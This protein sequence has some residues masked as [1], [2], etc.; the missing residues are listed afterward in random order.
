MTDQKVEIKKGQQGC[1]WSIFLWHKGMLWRMNSYGPL[2]TLA[3]PTLAKRTVRTYTQRPA[4]NW[5]CFINTTS[6]HHIDR[7]DKWHQ[8]KCCCLFAAQTASCSSSGEKWAHCFSTNW[9]ST[10]ANKHVTPHLQTH[11]TITKTSPLPFYYLLLKTKQEQLGRA[12]TTGW[13]TPHFFWARKCKLNRYYSCCAYY[14]Q[15]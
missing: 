7:S 3:A 14:F 6:L 12:V 4:A 15:F 2:L 5:M 8:P 9:S 11:A 13:A 1:G 10:S